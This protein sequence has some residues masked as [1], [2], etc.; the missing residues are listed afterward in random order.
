MKKRKSK[1]KGKA[2]RVTGA[3]GISQRVQVIHGE[4]GNSRG[5]VESIGANG[6]TVRVHGRLAVSVPA[7][8]LIAL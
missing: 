4:Y 7:D 2:A 8:N 1:A 3:F 5:V 6:V